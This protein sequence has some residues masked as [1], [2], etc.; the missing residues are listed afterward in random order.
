MACE[1]RLKGGVDGLEAVARMPMAGCDDRQ[2]R[3]PMAATGAA[4]GVEQLLPPDH[5]STP[6]AFGK[7]SPDPQRF[8]SIDR[9]LDGP[10]TRRFRVQKGCASFDHPYAVH[11]KLELTARK[12][13]G[14]KP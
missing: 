3:F 9:S 8:W 4:L 14:V 12:Q 5:R 6:S 7:T 2:N 11:D 1:V 10:L 13:G